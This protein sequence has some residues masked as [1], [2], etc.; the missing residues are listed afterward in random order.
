M[1]HPAKAKVEDWRVEAYYGRFTVL[2]GL[3]YFKKVEE[4]RKFQ[5]T[6]VRGT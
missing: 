5:G 2:A 4:K 6:T 3:C 1:Q